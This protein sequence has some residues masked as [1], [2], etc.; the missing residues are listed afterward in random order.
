M[1]S[2]KTS[3]NKIGMNEIGFNKTVDLSVVQ[4][5]RLSSTVL[6]T[7]RGRDA[8]TFG[9]YNWALEKVIR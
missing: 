3:L 6:T 5:G 8:N 1:G 7:F 9:A 4:L 2:K